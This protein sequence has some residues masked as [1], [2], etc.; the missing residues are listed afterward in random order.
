MT[1]WT[2]DRKAR[3]RELWNAGVSRAEICEK[4]G[5][6]AGQLCGAMMRLNLRSRSVSAKVEPLHA[7]HPALVEGRSVW[8]WNVK[9][10]G[11]IG[12]ERTAL[13]SGRD[14]R[15]LGNEIEKGPWK[16]MRVYSLTL[17]ERA[18][19]P[20]SCHLWGL[21]YGNAMQLAARNKHGPELEA[22]LERE[23]G[24]LSA[25]HIR[26]GYAVRLHIL[27]DFYSTDYVAFWRRMLDWHPRL[28]V[29]GYTAW[30]R[31]T[32]IGAAI[33]EITRRHWRRFAIRVSSLAPG[34]RNVV[35]LR[36]LQDMDP[37]LLAP[38]GGNVIVC[39]VE[40]G[41][42]LSCS[43]CGLCWSPEARDKSIAF[44]LHGTTR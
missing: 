40:T 34:R 3:V 8:Q 35:T 24:V 7:H 33:E 18:T 13:K 9:P 5:L 10:V 12:V 29:W 27:G 1:V 14:N 23:L 17:E 31:D 39:P 42:T 43:T 20:R 15:K 41:R 19:C 4:E 38:R 25:R 36:L 37:S 21:C 2:E 22:A 32:E 30:Q 11:A 26:T 6:T 44:I 16:G 28:H